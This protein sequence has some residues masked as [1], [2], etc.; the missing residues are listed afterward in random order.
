MNILVLGATGMLGSAVFRHLSQIDTYKV[1]GTTTSN[2]EV[3]V[4]YNV[5]TRQISDLVSQFDP[6][7]IINCIGKIKI[8]RAH[9]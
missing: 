5:L 1:I 2:S 6:E 4:K 8:G 9:V 3:F 7:Y